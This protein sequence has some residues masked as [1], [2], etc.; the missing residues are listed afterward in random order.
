MTGRLYK[1]LIFFRLKGTFASLK[2]GTG[3]I[4]KLHDDLSVIDLI[5]GAKVISLRGGQHKFSDRSGPR[6]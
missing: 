4:N 2:N 6:T 5:A 1:A 3:Y